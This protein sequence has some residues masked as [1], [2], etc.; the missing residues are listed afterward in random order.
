MKSI[1]KI[2]ISTIFQSIILSLLVLFLFFAATKLIWTAFFISFQEGTFYFIT[3]LLLICFALMVCIGIFGVLLAGLNK[4]YWDKEYL[5]VYYLGFFRKKYPLSKLKSFYVSSVRGNL[6]YKTK[7]Y[8]VIYFCFEDQKN[9]KNILSFASKDFKNFDFLVTKTQSLA[10]PE[11]RALSSKFSLFFWILLGNIVFLLL[12][13]G[14]YKIN[15]SPS[16]LV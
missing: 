14:F 4:W 10:I 5:N 11:D 2:S 7:G 9:K 12:L 15:S 16:I 6:K 13:L 3:A 8:Q 1:T